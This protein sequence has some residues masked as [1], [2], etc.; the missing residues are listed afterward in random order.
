[1]VWKNPTKRIIP[2]INSYTD[3][4]E[5]YAAFVRKQLPTVEVTVHYGADANE[6]GVSWTFED[7]FSANQFFGNYYQRYLQKSESLEALFAEQFESI[8]DLMPHSEQ[9]FN[10]SQIFPLIKTLGWQQTIQ[11]QFA[12]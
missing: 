9:T 8:S 11:A 10:P 6:T 5:K 1:M 2:D 3:Y 12:S 4:S 7:G